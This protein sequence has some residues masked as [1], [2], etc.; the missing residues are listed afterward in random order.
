MFRLIALNHFKEASIQIG[1]K[2][3][4][5][6]KDDDMNNHL[7]VKTTTQS[8]AGG[9]SVSP[10]G[11]E[12]MEAVKSRAGVKH[13]KAP[14]KDPKE[15]D[16]TGDTKDDRVI[17]GDRTDKQDKDEKDD[18]GQDSS[19]TEDSAD[20]EDSDRE[21]DRDARQSSHSTPGSRRSDGRHQSAGAT[22]RGHVTRRRRHIHRRKKK[23]HVPV[24]LA[25][26]GKVCVEVAT[27]KTVASVV[28]Q[29]GSFEE[30][31]PSTELLPVLHLDELEF[32]P[33]DFVVDKQGKI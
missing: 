6:L 12:S 11:K 17:K 27:T 7:V 16:E 21:N 4:F 3:Y 10:S 5:I 19:S 1:D 9:G 18:E 31:I 33:G 28:W 13:R 2:A 26:G 15:R 29:D 30:H 8:I 20:D 25:P 22:A 23:H 24:N 14:L 32:F